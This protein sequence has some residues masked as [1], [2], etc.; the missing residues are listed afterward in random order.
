MPRRARSI[1]GGYVYHVLNRS[2]ARAKLFL[3]EEDYAAFE[4][5]LDEAILSVPLADPRVPRDAQSLAHGDMASGRLGSLGLGLS[6]W[7]T[8]THAQ[9]WHAHYHS[10]GSGHLYQGRYKSF[11]VESDEISTRCCA[12]SSAIP[13]G[14]TWSNGRK[15]GDGR[16]S[17]ATPREMT[18]SVNCWPPGRSLDRR[19]G[20]CGSTEPR[21]RWSWKRFAAACSTDSP[22][23]ASYGANGSSRLWV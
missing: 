14:P 15:T 3:K 8:V 4:R 18:R 10:S 17:V 6:R 20:P 7:L 23:A 13:C 2:N 21:A 11:P 16:V 22:T 1:Q 12:T 5:I 19:T 9:R